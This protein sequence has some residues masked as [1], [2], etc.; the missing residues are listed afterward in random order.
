[1]KPWLVFS[2]R[3]R[4]G[5]FIYNISMAHAA[6]PAPCCCT[7]SDA[8]STF[9]RSLHSA[10]LLCLSQGP[11]EMLKGPGFVFCSP[12]SQ[13]SPC[14]GQKHLKFPVGQSQPGTV[15]VHSEGE[16]PSLLLSTAHAFV[17]QIRPLGELRAGH[18]W[19]VSAPSS[20]APLEQP[21]MLMLYCVSLRSYYL[22]LS[23]CT[24]HL[25]ALAILRGL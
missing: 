24:Q 15:G 8:R 17:P 9:S 18:E 3:K 21:R 6:P 22:F 14:L 10:G 2:R 20:R 7:T 1:M 5:A 12:Q 19:S 13:W 25:P 11:A 23:L 16:S 4:D